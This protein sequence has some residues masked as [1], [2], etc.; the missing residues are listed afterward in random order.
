MNNHHRW[1]AWNRLVH[2]IPGGHCGHGYSTKPSTEF[3]S[4]SD[5]THLHYG[6][7]LIH[8]LCNMSILCTIIRNMWPRSGLRFD[9]RWEQI[10]RRMKLI[11]LLYNL[12][13]GVLKRRWNFNNTSDLGVASSVLLSMQFQ[14]TDSVFFS[15]VSDWFRSADSLS[16]PVSD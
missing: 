16:S 9:T 3:D 1:V 15:P 11:Q 8:S 12:M 4:C 10:E 2:M 14:L 5:L 13:S 7:T 6:F